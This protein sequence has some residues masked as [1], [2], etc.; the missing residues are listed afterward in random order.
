MFLICATADPKKKQVVVV[1]V[2]VVVRMD[3]YLPHN[4]LS[5]FSH[6]LDQAQKRSWQNENQQMSEE[7]FRGAEEALNR[8][9]MTTLV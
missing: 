3:L 1:V 4:K 9:K 5:R 2:V 8:R 6:D 7:G